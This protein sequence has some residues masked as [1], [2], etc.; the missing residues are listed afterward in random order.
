MCF[1]DS[2]DGLLINQEMPSGDDCIVLIWKKPIYQKEKEQKYMPLIW[3]FLLSCH[4]FVHHQ[5]DKNI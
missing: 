1:C 5:N 2:M 4:V 3:R